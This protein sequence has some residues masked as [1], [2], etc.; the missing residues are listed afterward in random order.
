MRA[1]LFQRFVLLYSTKFRILNNEAAKNNVVTTSVKTTTFDA[2]VES[3]EV[4]KIDLV[5]IDTEGTEHLIL[6][7][8]EVVLSKLKPIIICETLFNTNE[9]K[10]QQIF[11]RHGYEFYNHTPK[12]LMQV[13]TITREKDNGIRNCF[14]VH[15]EKRS[16][17]EEFVID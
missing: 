11:E 7:H 5:K 1:F 3:N 4:D 16:L 13:E 6:S 2:Y 17:I 12:G 15:P 14:F 8:A 10:L 9:D